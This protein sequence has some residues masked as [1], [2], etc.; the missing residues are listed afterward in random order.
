MNSSTIPHP[1]NA[2]WMP[3]IDPNDEVRNN[4]FL[5]Y[6]ITIRSNDWG[7]VQKYFE[8]GFSRRPRDLWDERGVIIIVIM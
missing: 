3:P 6:S 2:S 1:P 8:S 7:R 4:S 5:G